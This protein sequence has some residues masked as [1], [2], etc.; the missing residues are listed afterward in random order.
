MREKKRRKRGKRG[1][2]RLQLRRLWFN[3]TPLPSMILGN[4]QSLRNKVD[5]LQGNVCFQKDF[6]DCCLMAFTETWL[7]EHDQDSDL[8][9]NGFGAPHHLDRN[10]EVTKKTQGGGVCVYVNQRYCNSVTV[11]ERICTPDVE[12]LSVSLRPF[13]L[14]CEFPQLFITAVYIHPKANA[15][16]ACK[17]IF[18]VVQKLQSILPDAPNFILGDFNHVSLKK[19]VPNFY[20][21]VSCPTRWDKILDLCY[22]SVK[23]AYKS[24]PLPPLGS[25]DHNCVHLLP[26]HR[27][28]LK[29]EKVQTK[30]IKDWTEES[31]LCLQECY[32]CTDWNMFIEACGDDLDELADVTC[33]Y[34]AFCRDMII[35]CKRV[36]NLPQ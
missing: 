9:I 18:D 15:S 3:Q 22:G 17:I 34:A 31:V 10:A 35:P 29:R 19:T 13:Y 32:D 36:K 8:L 26:T 7:T 33:S 20:Q 6:R 12:L 28:V 2:V 27:T 30:D 1:G 24:S 21:Y 23:E 25:G 16:S 4:V 5:E 14:P 11:R